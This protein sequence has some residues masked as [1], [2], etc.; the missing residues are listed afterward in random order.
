MYDNS[1]RE[2]RDANTNPLIS[3]REEKSYGT[4]KHIIK[5]KPTL[6]AEYIRSISQNGDVSI[7]SSEND[8]SNK[9]SSHVSIDGFTCSSR[10][11]TSEK[12]GNRSGLDHSPCAKTFN[13]KYASI[14]GSTLA[15]RRLSLTGF[16]ALYGIQNNVDWPYI[17]GS[18]LFIQ[19]SSYDILLSGLW[20]EQMKIPNNKGRYLSRLSENRQLRDN[21]NQ[22]KSIINPKNKGAFSFVFHLCGIVSSSILLSSAEM[23]I[24]HP[25]L[26]VVPIS[27]LY[28]VVSLS[29]RIIEAIEKSSISILS[30]LTKKYS[31]TNKTLLPV[32]DSRI[33]IAG[34]WINTH[35]RHLSVFKIFSSIIASASVTQYFDYSNEPIWRT[36]FVSSI[37]FISLTSLLL[38]N[39]RNNRINHYHLDNQK[40]K[41]CGLFVK[42]VLNMYCLYIITDKAT[43]INR[44]KI[45]RGSWFRLTGLLL[46]ASVGIGTAAICI[47]SELIPH[48]INS[49]YRFSDR[50]YLDESMLFAALFLCFI[51][52]Y[53]L[54]RSCSES[55]LSVIA[56]SSFDSLIGACG[57]LASLQAIYPEIQK[58]D[59]KSFAIFISSF[60]TL[61]AST[62]YVPYL[63][64]KV[65][66]RNMLSKY[67]TLSFRDGST[68]TNAL[69]EVA[70]SNPIQAP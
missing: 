19:S 18:Y 49:T 61:I 62:S 42:Y 23:A 69:E 68:D 43:S 45:N 37:F 57:T 30:L 5:C 12:S 29:G 46:L 24:I 8:D 28:F 66:S 31:N 63:Y 47:S 53:S 70:T 54:I 51:S 65:A 26:E 1:I 15:L 35:R 20:V 52:T 48:P 6:S 55:S 36:L 13:I 60:L 25:I 32:L 4:G 14:H 39:Y 27:I 59:S 16:I 44:D 41:G 10:S 22:V 38:E 64:D 11:G 40:T 50:L 3:E 33:L 2:K 7:S 21:T 56:S 17:L 58:N 9:L 34:S 67:S